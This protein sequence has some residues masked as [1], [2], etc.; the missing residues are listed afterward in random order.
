VPGAKVRADDTSPQLHKQSRWRA[1]R[2]D[3]RRD[4]WSTGDSS[5]QCMHASARNLSSETTD[6]RS[7]APAAS[8]CGRKATATRMALCT[9][10][11]VAD[12]CNYACAPVAT[13]AAG[14]ASAR[15]CEQQAGEC[16]RSVRLQTVCAK[17]PNNRR[18]HKRN[19][20]Q[21]MRATDHCFQHWGACA[22]GVQGHRAPRADQWL[23]APNSSRFHG[24]T[25]CLGAASASAC[26]PCMMPWKPL[27]RVLAPTVW[28]CTRSTSPSRRTHRMC[29]LRRDLVLPL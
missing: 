22:T 3:P 7:H 21:I 4:H 25:C 10:I 8:T 9:C 23:W 13:Q 16:C 11:L 2:P 29:A 6:S 26:S 1:C 17:P 5:A 24:P 14:K 28:T 27:S 18:A 15:G 19:T 20:T 12:A